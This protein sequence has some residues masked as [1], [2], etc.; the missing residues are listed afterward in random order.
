MKFW[1]Q[2]V[3]FTDW[4]V[5]RYAPEEPTSPQEV[6]PTPEPAPTPPEAPKYLWDTKANIRHSTRV[7]CDEEGLTA[8]QKNTI[9]ATIQAESGFNLTA[10]NDNKV[11]GKVTSTDW[12]LCQWNSYYHAKEIT[13]EEAVHD[14]EKAVRLMCSYWKRGQRNLWIAYK[15]NSYLKYL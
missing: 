4:L 8:E 2:F 7:I 9:C 5:A 11:N 3:A 14:P 13:P 12:G 6:P 15:N 1:K 10:R